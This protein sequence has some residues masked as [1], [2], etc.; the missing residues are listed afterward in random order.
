MTLIKW[1]GNRVFPTVSTFFDDL[2]N[3]DSDFLNLSKTGMTI[4]AVN[5]A[6]TTD[7]YNVELA[8]PGKSKD[9]FNIDVKNGS[10]VISSQTEEDSETTEKDFKRREYSYSSFSRSF[11]L[12]QNVNKNDISATYTDGILTV[13]LP[14]TAPSNP[15]KISVEVQ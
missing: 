12:P 11:G 10:L 3:E 7:S 13:R 1:P 8:V 4:P 5:I 2:F 6:E 15:E 9:D 14:K